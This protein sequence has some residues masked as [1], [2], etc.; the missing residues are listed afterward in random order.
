M[1]YIVQVWCTGI[2]W[3]NSKFGGDTMKEAVNA[4]IEL[5]ADDSK[6]VNPKAERRTQIISN[7]NNFT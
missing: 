1:K 2:G 7:I 4:Q 6:W 3:A 5:M